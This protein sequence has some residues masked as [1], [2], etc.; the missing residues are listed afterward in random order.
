MKTQKVKAVAE[1]V[2]VSETALL[3]QKSTFAPG[4]KPRRSG[5]GHRNHSLSNH[6]LR[7]VDAR[8]SS[9]GTNRRA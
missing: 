2:P 1:G 6:L 4:R 7:I 5:R 8:R 9:I 3:L